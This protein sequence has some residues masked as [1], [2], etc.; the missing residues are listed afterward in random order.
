MITHAIFI[1]GANINIRFGRIGK[2]TV[3]CCCTK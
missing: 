2:Q 3:L 1:Y